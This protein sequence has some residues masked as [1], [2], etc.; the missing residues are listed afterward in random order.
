MTG[1][2]PTV[3]HPP[4]TEE[5]SVFPEHIPTQNVVVNNN[6]M[7]VVNREEGGRMTSRQPVVSTIHSEDISFGE[8]R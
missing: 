2:E 6:Q 8:S 4:G 3:D 1:L 7:N 5:L